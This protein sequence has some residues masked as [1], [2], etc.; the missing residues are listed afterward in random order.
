MCAGEGVGE[1]GEDGEFNVVDEVAVVE[2]LSPG[3]LV[4]EGTVEI[5][6]EGD[7]GCEGKSERIVVGGS[8]AAMDGR[9]P[10]LLL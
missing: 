9:K 7:G 4:V 10:R 6:E 3:E 5:G 1:D 2:L 8:E